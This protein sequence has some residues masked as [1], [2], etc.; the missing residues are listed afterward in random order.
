MSVNLNK[1]RCLQPHIQLDE[2][3]IY[4][5]H[6]FLY[7]GQNDKFHKGLIQNIHTS[8][9]CLHFPNHP[10]KLLT[11]PPLHK[12]FNNLTLDSKKAIQLVL[13][14]PNNLSNIS[15][16]FFKCPLHGQCWKQLELTLFPSLNY[17]F[18]VYLNTPLCSC[19]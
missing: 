12:C 11:I 17:K 7:Y 14:P 13:N 8:I 16:L 1:S 15:T 18:C 3:F 2:N 9:P 5:Y 10:W 4:I 19:S 6:P